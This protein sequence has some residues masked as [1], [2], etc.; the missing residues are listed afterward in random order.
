MITFVI[1]ISFTVMLIEYSRR[2]I[3]VNYQ[4]LPYLARMR[5]ELLKGEPFSPLYFQKTSMIIDA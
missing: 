3:V 5:R 4:F 2:S 1:R